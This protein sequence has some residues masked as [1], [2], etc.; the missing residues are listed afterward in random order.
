MTASVHRAIKSGVQLHSFTRNHI[1]VAH[2]LKS[3]PWLYL[4]VG[5]WVCL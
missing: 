2:R 5:V 1:F 4:Y 3:S